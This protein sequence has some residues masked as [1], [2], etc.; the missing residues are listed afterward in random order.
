MAALQAPFPVVWSATGGKIDSSGQ[1]TAGPTAGN[2]RAI[3]S[4]SVGRPGRYLHCY[5]HGFARDGAGCRIDAGKRHGRGRKTVQFSA[6]WPQ[7]GRRPGGHIS[8]L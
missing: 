6:S 3:A 7:C 5:S 1:Y 8:D 4:D 2:Y